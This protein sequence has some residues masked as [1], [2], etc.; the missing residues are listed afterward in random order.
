MSTPD[1][2]TH[3]LKSFRLLTLIGLDPND[4]DLELPEGVD[5][6]IK[7]PHQ[8]LKAA[9]PPLMFRPGT[10]PLRKKSTL[11]RIG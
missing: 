10:R 5:Y 4:D 2:R 9:K 3:R 6:I 8:V 7:G 11:G 1:D